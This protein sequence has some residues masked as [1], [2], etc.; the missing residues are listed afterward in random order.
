MSVSLGRPRRNVNNENLLPKHRDTRAMF[1]QAG[2]S[3]TGGLPPHIIDIINSQV[4]QMEIQEDDPLKATEEAI[5]R[6]INNAV[7]VLKDYVSEL[8]DRDRMAQMACMY[9][10][11]YAFGV[12]MRKDY[13]VEELKDLADTTYENS[14]KNSGPGTSF[15]VIMK[16]LFSKTDLVAEAYAFICIITT[17]RLPRAPMMWHLKMDKR[18]AWM[19]PIQKDCEDVVLTMISYLLEKSENKDDMIEGIST[20]FYVLAACTLYR[21]KD[22][23]GVIMEKYRGILKLDESNRWKNHRDIRE[24]VERLIGCMVEDGDIEGLRVISRDVLPEGYTQKVDDCINQLFFRKDVDNGRSFLID[25][26]ENPPRDIKAW[27]DFEEGKNLKEFHPF[28]TDNPEH[29]L[30]IVS[31]NLHIK[32]RN[33]D[34]ILFYPCNS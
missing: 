22:L 1:N 3:W 30:H 5:K 28:H 14:F 7:D 9:G 21:W 34:P 25:N 6:G 19:P 17:A 11:S 10:N 4:F 16:T 24:E 26:W 29:L 15:S 20:T 8:G 27:T 32:F 18:I 2:K 31:N 13:T 23:R 33:H 12:F